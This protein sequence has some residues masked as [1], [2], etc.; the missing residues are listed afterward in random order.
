[1]K[2]KLQSQLNCS[3]ETA[4]EEVKK[5][6]LLQHVASPLVT[7]FPEDPAVFPVYWPEHETTLVRFNL[8]GL[9]GR[10]HV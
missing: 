3:P 9:I 1:M 2:I 10:A 7:F 6:S 8:F 4:W 5:V